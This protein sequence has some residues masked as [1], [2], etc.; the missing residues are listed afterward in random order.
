MG[1]PRFEPVEDTGDGRQYRKQDQQVDERFARLD[2]THRQRADHTNP[3][4]RDN[5]RHTEA[6]GQ[7]Q[8]SLI[9][10]D[11]FHQFAHSARPAKPFRLDNGV[12]WSE[13]RFLAIGWPLRPNGLQ[14][15]DAANHDLGLKGFLRLR[16]H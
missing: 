16:C 10:D 6:E 9:R 4:E 2:R 15:S 5:S 7:R 3:D 14:R 13:L 11:V 1:D 12:S 8:F